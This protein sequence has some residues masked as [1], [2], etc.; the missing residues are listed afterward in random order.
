MFCLSQI[1]HQ[2]TSQK[3][4]KQHMKITGQDIQVLLFQISLT[5]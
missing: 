2:F 5:D 4:L 1:W 3:I